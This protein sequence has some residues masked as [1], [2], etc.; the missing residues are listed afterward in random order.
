MEW[1]RYVQ[2]QGGGVG[3]EV[4]GIVWDLPGTWGQEVGYIG[5]VGPI[6]GYIT[7]SKRS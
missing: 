6:S 4:L 2:G 3:V 1:C 5:W 7:I